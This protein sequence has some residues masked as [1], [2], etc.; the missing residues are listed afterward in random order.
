M[1]ETDN[2]L[3]ELTL[4][5]RRADQLGITYSNNIGVDKLREKVNAAIEGEDTQSAIDKAKADNDKQ[6]L[7]QALIKDAK[8]LIRLRIVDLD[9]KKKDCPGE[10][11]SVGNRWVG[12]IRRYVPYGDVTENGWHVEN[13]LYKFMKNRK[14]QSITTKKNSKGQMVVEERW[15]PEYSLTVLPPLTQKELNELAQAQQ[16]RGSID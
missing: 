8:K 4:L 9:P 16:A 5:K 13:I 2:Q 11:L 15:V 7:R 6:A 10:I 12:T 1:A 3:D 14:F